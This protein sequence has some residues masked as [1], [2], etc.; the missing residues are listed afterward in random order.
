MPDGCE[1]WFWSESLSEAPVALTAVAQDYLKAV[2]NAQEWSDEPLTVKDLA[3]RLGVTAG[4]VSEGLRRLVAAGLIDHERYGEVSLTE[5]G[6][7][8]ALSVVRRHRL[9]ETLLVETFGY[10]WDEVHDEAEVLEH[11]ISD[12]LVARIDAHLGFPRV[13]PHGDPIPTAEGDITIPNARRLSELV[14]GE[15]GVVTRVLDADPGLLQRLARGGVVPG[16][17]IRVVEHDVASS[18]MVIGVLGQDAELDSPFG[19]PAL[20]SVWV[21][22]D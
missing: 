22:G 19:T 13:D 15:V 10:T 3:A 21:V 9:V 16:A 8:A 20:A 11:A 1:N 12:D 4:T 2:W 18:L 17:R 7:R 6:R 5:Q 14:A